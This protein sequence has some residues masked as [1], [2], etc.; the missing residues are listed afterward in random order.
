M[1]HVV[2]TEAKSKN[3]TK[4]EE[5]TLEVFVDRDP[6]HF[7]TI[8]EYLRN[9]ADGVYMHPSVARLLANLE[10]SSCKSNNRQ[11]EGDVRD[12][13]QTIANE[14]TTHTTNKSISTISFIELPKDSKTLAEL[15][16]ES[17]FYNIPELT[18]HIC[19]NRK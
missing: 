6:K 15:Y 4:R 19:C 16:F 3:N 14:D 11:D 18:D 8:L 9:K 12:G 17:I 2:R 7:G 10:D 5:Q 1:D 13:T